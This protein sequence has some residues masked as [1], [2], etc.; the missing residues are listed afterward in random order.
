MINPDLPFRITPADIE[1][2]TESARKQLEITYVEL[3]W[4]A[5]KS[6]PE[7]ETQIR[8]SYNKIKDRLNTKVV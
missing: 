7:L 4:L 1:R 3:V 2:S 6:K 5:R 8:E